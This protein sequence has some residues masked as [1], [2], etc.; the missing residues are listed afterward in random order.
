MNA[1]FLFLLAHRVAECFVNKQFSDKTMILMKNLDFYKSLPGE[2]HWFWMAAALADGA[3]IAHRL[4]VLL[5]V[6]DEGRA[7][8]PR[9][10]AAVAL[11]RV[12]PRVP[13]SVVYQVVRAL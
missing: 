8:R 6:V 9:P 1:G 7:V 2:Q 4:V 13:P 11:V 5:L 12:L 10:V 3:Q